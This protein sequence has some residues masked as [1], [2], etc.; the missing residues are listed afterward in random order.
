[1]LNC[2]VQLL[3][4]NQSKNKYHVEIASVLAKMIYYNSPQKNFPA[5]E[6]I[7]EV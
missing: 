5:N 7:L 1:M 2:Q 4:I 3:N 6:S